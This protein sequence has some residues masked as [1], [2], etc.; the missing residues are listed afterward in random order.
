MSL[1][2]IGSKHNSVE[3]L[4]GLAFT[5]LLHTSAAFIASLASSG[6][7]SPDNTHMLQAVTCFSTKV[8][9]H[10]ES[11]LAKEVLAHGS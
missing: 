9:P 1:T 11:I 7:C 5:S 8:S 6:F 3:V 2:Q 4:V 10:E